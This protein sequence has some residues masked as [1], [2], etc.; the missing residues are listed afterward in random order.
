[1]YRYNEAKQLIWVFKIPRVTVNQTIA[2]KWS[3]I[4]IENSPRRY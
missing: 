3:L 4:F 2:S 1:M